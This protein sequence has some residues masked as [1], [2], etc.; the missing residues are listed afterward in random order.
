[1]KTNCSI[2]HAPSGIFYVWYYD[3]EGMRQKI[4][5][6]RRLKAGAKKKTTTGDAGALEHLKWAGL[7]QEKKLLR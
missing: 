3:R 2:S 6:G 5:T 7:S 4:S 1:M